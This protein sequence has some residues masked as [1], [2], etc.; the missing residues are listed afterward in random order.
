MTSR[1][2]LKRTDGAVGEW[3][4]NTGAGE[5]RRT[6]FT[7]TIPRYSPVFLA[8]SPQTQGFRSFSN[9]R[10]AWK[11]SLQLHH[12]PLEGRLPP[13]PYNSPDPPSHSPCLPPPTSDESKNRPNS[14][15]T[16]CTFSHPPLTRN[17]LLCTPLLAARRQDPRPRCP[18]AVPCRHGRRP[19]SIPCA[20]TRLLARII[21]ERPWK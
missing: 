3:A 11:P 14:L 15:H 2:L 21:H 10:T 1:I 9:S 7:P 12:R 16:N 17:A 13:R 8:A 4:A 19:I 6:S 20:R 5:G 18:W